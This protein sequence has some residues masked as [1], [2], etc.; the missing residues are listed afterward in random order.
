M[1]N[2]KTARNLLAEGKYRE[3]EEILDR[4]IREN[5]ENDELWYFLG[6][7]AVKLKNYD[8][9]REYL[10]RALSLNKKPE[11]LWFKGMTFMETLEIEDAIGSFEE[12]LEI[13]KNN[14]NA[15]FFLSICYLLLD[16]PR[17]EKYLKKSY[18]LDGKKT[19]QLLNNFFEV[20]INKRVLIAGL[21]SKIEKEI[22]D[23]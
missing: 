2:L 16:D 20:F 18:E 1:D 11:Y 3:A 17:S 4:L 14:I 10:E 15:N 19:K 5:R 7:L 22:E 6:V 12:V 23:L 8:S 13:D 21:K 9:A